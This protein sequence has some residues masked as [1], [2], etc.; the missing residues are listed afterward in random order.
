[1]TLR[2]EE[3]YLDKFMKALRSVAKKAAESGST[4]TWEEKEPSFEEIIRKKNILQKHCQIQMKI[5]IHQN[6]VMILQKS[7]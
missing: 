7:N 2:I 1:M 4:C 5:K 6:Q 3:S